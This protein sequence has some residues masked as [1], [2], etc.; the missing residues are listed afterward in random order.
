M[1]KII[2]LFLTIVLICGMFIL[3]ASAVNAKKITPELQKKLDKMSDTDTIEVYVPISYYLGNKEQT[4][5]A[6]RRAEEETGL[7]LDSSRPY[8]KVETNEE[9]ERY[10]TAFYA[11]LQDVYKR[12]ILS[13]MDEM[14]LTFDD[15]CGANE[16][17]TI[18]DI[19]IPSNYRLTK[20]HIYRLTEFDRV[21]KI[22][23]L[24]KEQITPDE[25]I[26]PELQA[27]LD[28]M[29]DDD[30]TEVWIEYWGLQ[31]WNESE[32]ERLTNEA[33]GFTMKDVHEVTK[34]DRVLANDMVNIW[35]RMRNKIRQQLQHQFWVDFFKE[36]NI[37]DSEVIG[38]W[39]PED[40]QWGYGSNRFVLSKKKILAIAA[41]EKI[42][43]IKPDEPIEYDDCYYL[44][45][46]KDNWDVEKGYRLTR[47]DY[48]Y[49]G[50]G[51]IGTRDITMSA[52]DRVKV[53]FSRDGKTA[54]RWYP[55]E[56]D[57]GYAPGY[58][59]RSI[60]IF[61]YRSANGTDPLCYKGFLLAYPCEPP[62]VE[63]TQLPTDT[64]TY[65]VIVPNVI[66]GDVDN[67]GDLTIL[68]AT[69]IQR[70]LADLPS[71]SYAVWNADYDDDGSV[72]ILDATA[73]QRKL[74]DLT[75]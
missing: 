68:D 23:L 11:A 51:E 5:E 34:T 49:Y 30:T 12:F 48:D 38:E 10:D 18:D 56:E 73:I 61:F 70:M 2:A 19:K 44:V 59:S 22:D 65:S 71:E 37:E 26:T 69:A 43:E 28:T 33:V 32:L 47:L 57:E 50:Y 67:D 14:G 29:S 4:D 54:E 16:G 13:V 39:H 24:N 25:K 17:Y 40:E 36:L 35:R 1:K 64:P 7:T 20:E 72:T 6:A 60:R 31:T 15:V 41:H 75:E 21:Y 9:R 3:P 45:F 42:R 58:D 66:P 53:V 55:S 74:A 63:P 8:K 62:I 52:D 27:R 46:E